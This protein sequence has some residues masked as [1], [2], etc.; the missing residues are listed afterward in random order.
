M[1]NYLQKL[2]N[3]KFSVNLTKNKKGNGTNKA[4]KKEQHE[5]ITTIIL[6]QL[7]CI[8]HLAIV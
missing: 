7:M 2:A 8:K 1:G 3:W 4:I 5:M 6:K